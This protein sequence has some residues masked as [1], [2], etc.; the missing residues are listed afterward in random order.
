MKQGNVVSLAA[1]KAQKLK[2]QELVR[3]RKPLYESHSNENR[4]TDR[5]KGQNNH[6][7]SF[8]ERINR[9]RSSLDKINALMLE[10][11]KISAKN[12]GL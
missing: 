2:R 8:E 11:K 1:F 5:F 10:L 7:Q 12:S 4:T 9:I 3:G 6:E